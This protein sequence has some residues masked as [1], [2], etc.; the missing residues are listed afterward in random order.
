MIIYPDC[1]DNEERERERRDI[2]EE[3]E[4]SEEWEAMTWRNRKILTL[5]KYLPARDDLSWH[6]IEM[7]REVTHW[8]KKKWS[9]LEG[10]EMKMLSGRDI[11]VNESLRCMTWSALTVMEATSGWVRVGGGGVEKGR[12]GSKKAWRGQRENGRIFGL[13]RYWAVRNN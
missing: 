9:E 5:T 6:D 1:N 4:D 2:R 3:S 10:R 7:K 13:M 12:E 8:T 11:C